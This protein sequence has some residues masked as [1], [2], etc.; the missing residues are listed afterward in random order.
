MNEFVIKTSMVET[1]TR[2]NV[3]LTRLSVVILFLIIIQHFPFSFIIYFHPFVLFSILVLLHMYTNNVL[4]Q[5]SVLVC[6]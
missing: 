2:S 1:Q 5:Y 4:V 3:S 6:V